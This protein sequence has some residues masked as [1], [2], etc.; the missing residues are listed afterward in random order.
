MCGP[1]ERIVVLS[2][3]QVGLVDKRNNINIPLVSTSIR[4]SLLDI[5]AEVELEQTY[6]NNTN[7]PIE[8][9]YKVFFEGCV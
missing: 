2:M 4:A 1:V 8:A 3:A 9:I 5:I 6:I 7:E